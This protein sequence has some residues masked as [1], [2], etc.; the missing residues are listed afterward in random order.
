MD[1]RTS[2]LIFVS[3]F[4]PEKEGG[5][6]AF[7]LDP[8]TGAIAAAKETPGI[9]HP[10]FIAVAP[11]GKT[12]YS[13]R[14]DKFGGP[15]NGEVIAW[16]IADRDGTLELIGRSSTHGTVSCHLDVEPTGRTVLVS[17]YT[18]GNLVS[19]PLKSDGT[20]GD[21][22]SILQQTG[23]G[24]NPKRQKEPHPHSMMASPAHVDGQGGGRY[25][26]A[27]DLGTDSVLCFKLDAAKAELAPLDPPRAKTAPGSGP[28]HLAFHP[29]AS[30]LYCINEL[31]NTIVAFDV[32]PATG[33]LAERQTISTLPAGFTGESYTADLKFTPDGHFLYGT[34]R[35]HDSIAVYKVAADGKLETVEIV[36][37]LGKGP[38]NLAITPDGRFLLCANMPGKNLAV[39]RIDAATGRLTA[40]GEPT[41]IT[42]PACIRVVPR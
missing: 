42:S 18:T 10:F 22:V 5:I 34:N 28:R 31:D 6:R 32:D 9:P 35:G 40:A 41:A 3:M 12:L 13:I 16:R 24:A 15:E 29:H 11:D 17:N 23:S 27:A 19:L 39:F 2:L 7:H 21:A 1:P 26:Y 37:S 33:R 4:A 38:Q 36:P 8:A 30:R 25:A 14:A 20:P